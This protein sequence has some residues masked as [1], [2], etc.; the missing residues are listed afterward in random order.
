MLSE[1]RGTICDDPEAKAVL[2]AYIDRG[3]GDVEARKWFKYRQGKELGICLATFSSNLEHSNVKENKYV[4]P[5]QAVNYQGARLRVGKPVP[6][7]KR[8]EGEAI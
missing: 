1:Q 8:G 6:S 2:Q 7:G 4:D 5:Y 3:Y